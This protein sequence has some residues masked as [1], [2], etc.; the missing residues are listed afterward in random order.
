MPAPR[1]RWFRATWSAGLVGD[2]G[3]LVGI[4]GVPESEPNLT[5]KA[6]RPEHS[7][8]QAFGAQFFGSV[9]A[10]TAVFL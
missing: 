10:A 8:V 3:V 7:L 4:L 1:E 9:D 2:L 5:K 6:S